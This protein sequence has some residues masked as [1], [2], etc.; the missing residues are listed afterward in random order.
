MRHADRFFI[1][2]EWVE[3]SSGSVID[4]INS[5]TEQLLFSVAEAQ[6]ADMVRAVGAARQAFDE[7]PWPRLS[8][9][10]RELSPN[11][12]CVRLRSSHQPELL[13]AMPINLTTMISNGRR[14]VKVGC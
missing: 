6:E 8:H 3:P 2:G 4:V 13:A 10:Q 9:A 5:G 1:G 11:G 14:V 7:G 12:W